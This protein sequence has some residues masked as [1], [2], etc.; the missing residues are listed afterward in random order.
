M[1]RRAVVAIAGPG[2]QLFRYGGLMSGPVAAL[3][4]TGA[5]RDGF[6]LLI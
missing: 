1:G 5:G 3:K 2:W 6:S 4:L